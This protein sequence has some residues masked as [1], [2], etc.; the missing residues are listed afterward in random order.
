MASTDL[1]ASLQSTPTES[2]KIRPLD[3]YAQFKHTTKSTKN[4]PSEILTGMHNLNT[5]RRVLLF[6]VC[7]VIVIVR[8]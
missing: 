2:T 6:V 4:T 5:L 3:R 8:T 7:I 1:G